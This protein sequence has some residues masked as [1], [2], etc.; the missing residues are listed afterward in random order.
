MEQPQKKQ[1]LLISLR[2]LAA[3]PKTSQELKRKLQAKGFSESLIAETLQE[4]E[5]KGFLSDRAYAL[6]L[7]ARYR[8]SSP[9]GRRKIAFEFKRRGIA[10][11]IQDEVLAGYSQEEERE[12]AVSI[13]RDRWNRLAKLTDDKRKKRVM[14]FLM[15]R[16]FEYQ[17]VREAI[18][19][20]AKDTLDEDPS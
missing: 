11:K 12:Q 16:G 19:G 10:K 18:Q 8:G 14:D 20:I 13:A 5:D 6:N 4:L 3:S 17:I 15:R 1:A 2:L 7:M 9:S